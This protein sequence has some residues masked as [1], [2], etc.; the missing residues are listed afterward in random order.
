MLHHKNGMFMAHVYNALKFGHFW[1]LKRLA[2]LKIDLEK[3]NVE[4]VFRSHRYNLMAVIN[5]ENIKIIL[6]R[7]LG[8]SPR[9]STSITEP[10]HCGTTWRCFFSCLSPAKL[11]V[12]SSFHWK[13][14]TYSLARSCISHWNP[15]IGAQC[16]FL[17]LLENRINFVVQTTMQSM[18]C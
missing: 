14:K 12:I 5:S 3:K 1:W 8:H 16:V 17:L 15:K 13:C 7:S 6:F 4:L 2:L 10:M 18:F 9:L 11:R